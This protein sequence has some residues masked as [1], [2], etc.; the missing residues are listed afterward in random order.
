M[1]YLVIFLVYTSNGG[2]EDYSCAFCLFIFLYYISSGGVED[3]YCV[4]HLFIFLD[5]ASSGGVEDYS[6]VFYLFCL[7]RL[8]CALLILNLDLKFKQ[9]AKKVFKVSQKKNLKL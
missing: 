3:Y 6:C 1:F 2:V 5:Y 9:P 4:L 8:V 7:M